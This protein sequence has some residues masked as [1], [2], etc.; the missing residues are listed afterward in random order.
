MVF[1][2]LLQKFLEK[3]IGKYISGIDSNNIQIG[4]WKGKVDV[5]NVK[6]KKD[7]LD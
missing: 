5:K 4:L 3:S 1:E 2:D 6:L 7:I